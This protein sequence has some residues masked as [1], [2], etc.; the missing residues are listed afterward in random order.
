MHHHFPDLVQCYTSARIDQL[1]LGPAGADA[2]EC[3]PERE[4]WVG[5]CAV[6][7]YHLT[8]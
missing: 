2:E 1:C 3:E 5:C 7:T 4:R 8:S 6:V